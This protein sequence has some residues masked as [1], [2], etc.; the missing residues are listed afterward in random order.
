M[1]KKIGMTNF[2][3]SQVNEFETNTVLGTNYLR[4]V[5]DDLGGSGSVRQP[6]ITR[7][8]VVPYAGDHV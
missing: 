4:M 5:L 2:K 3:P 8:R 7:D 1:A 6:V